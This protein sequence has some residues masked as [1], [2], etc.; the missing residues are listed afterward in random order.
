MKLF[1]LFILLLLLSCNV[2]A[3]LDRKFAKIQAGAG[4][5]SAK[6]GQPDY[7]RLYYWASHPA[8]KDMADSVPTFLQGEKRDSLADVFFIHPTTFTKGMLTSG[9][10]ADVDD[11]VLNDYTDK[12]TIMLQAS[13]FNNSCRVFAPRYRQAHLKTFFN[14]GSEPNEAALDLAYQDVKAAFEYYLSHDNHGRPIIIAGHSQGAL[15][16]IRLL[17]E[18]FDGKPLQKQLV[19]AYVVGWQIKKDEFASLPFGA[20]ATQTGCVVGWRSFRNGTKDNF[21]EKE[22]GNSLCVNPITWATSETPSDKAMHKGMVGKEYDQVYDHIIAAS[23]EP[24]SKILW[25]SL[26]YAQDDSKGFANNFHIADFN[27]FY[28]DVR[29][30]AKQRIAAY[31]CK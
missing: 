26:P 25:V 31:L 11:S 13:I 21:I 23:V 30:N 4:D 8:K 6:P 18:Y 5:A 29:E 19:C 20:N 22:N 1:R 9:L 16:A 10:N 24:A 14:R 17:K 27:L 15:H 2:E 7:A 28:L 3:Q 12:R